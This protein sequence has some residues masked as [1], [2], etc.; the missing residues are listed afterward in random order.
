VDLARPPTATP[1]SEPRGPFAIDDRVVHRTLGAGV[2]QRVTVD[3]LT[4]L[5]EA[6]GYKTLDA[7]IV[8]E[9]GLLQ[10]ATAA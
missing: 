8:Q 5:F 10:L 4:V 3:S 2:I 1:D 6:A 9:Q 7:A